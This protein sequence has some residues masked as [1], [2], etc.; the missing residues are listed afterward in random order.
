MKKSKRRESLVNSEYTFSRFVKSHITLLII[1]CLIPII[2]CVVFI[3]LL[4]KCEINIWDLG[5]FLGGILAYVGTALLGAVSMWQNEKLKFENDKNLKREQERAE[6]EKN[7]LLENN[8]KMA[9]D[10]ARLAVIPIFSVRKISYSIHKD[11][12]DFSETEDSHEKPYG[13][14][15]SESQYFAITL[16]DKEIKVENTESNEI[17][18][19]KNSVLS[20]KEDSNGV[21]FFCG[22]TDAYIP[23]EIRNIG[24]A[25]ANKF[26]FAIY[27]EDCTSFELRKY[28]IARPFDLTETLR[29]DLYIPDLSI[30]TTYW[31]EFTYD[32]I[33]G[34]KYL[35]KDFIRVSKENSQFSIDFP[36]VLQ[37]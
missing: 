14:H 28:S 15:E 36:Q 23:Y 32:D 3:P 1:L 30:E 34:N 29:L 18:H 8:R 33:L 25:N 31:L 2:A 17:K 24:R 27:K 13:Y 11:L 22:K 19:Y 4:C 9:Y 21:I 37:E 12:L 16:G 20:R 35:Q 7:A 10:N 26:S 5:S 6:Q